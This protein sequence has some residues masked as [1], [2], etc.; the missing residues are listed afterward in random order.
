MSRNNRRLSSEPAPGPAPASEAKPVA[1]EPRPAEQPGAYSLLCVLA[2][3]IW[4]PA[5]SKRGQWKFHR[6]TRE[7]CGKTTEIRPAL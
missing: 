4:Q 2:G 1:P 3:H 6:C 7:G 5:K